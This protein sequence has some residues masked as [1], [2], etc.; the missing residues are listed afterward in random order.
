[1]FDRP[2]YG[3]V[4]AQTATDIPQKEGA[5]KD[6][7]KEIK[8]REAEERGTSAGTQLPA[9]ITAALESVDSIGGETREVEQMWTPMK[10]TVLSAADRVL[11]W[12]PRK[13]PDWFLKSEE[14]IQPLLD[15]KMRIYNRHLREN[16]AATNIA[17]REIK[18]KLQREIWAMKDKWWNEKAEEVQEMA[19]K[20]DSHSV[21]EGLTTFMAQEAMQWHLLR[22][23]MVASSTQIWKTSKLGGKSI[24]ATC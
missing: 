14:R 2:L 22:V 21:F 8:H 18:A 4:P 12:Q 3:P 15:E 11:G 13:T 20:N 17:F 19:D 23:L 5:F 6:T 16:S 9:A 24:S 1:M 7:I 10:E